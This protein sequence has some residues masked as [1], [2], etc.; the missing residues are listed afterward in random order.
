[1]GQDAA[2]ICNRLQS[3]LILCDWLEGTL[4]VGCSGLR[5]AKRGGMVE[6]RR[7]LAGG[8]AVRAVTAHQTEAA[9]AKLPV[10]SLSVLQLNVLKGVGFYLPPRFLQPGGL[11]AQTV[12]QACWTPLRT[13][14]G[15]TSHIRSKVCQC[16]RRCGASA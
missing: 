16:S 3:V 10:R 12:L 8:R 5:W 4:H 7:R 11:V 9:R 13:W 14:R 6:W 2:L 15:V 1:M